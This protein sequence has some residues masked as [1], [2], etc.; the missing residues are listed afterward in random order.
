[1]RQAGVLAAA[2]IV[3]LE[4]MVS[5]LGQDHA[6]ARTLAEGLSENPC[7]VLDAGTPATNMVFMNLNDDVPQSA[8]EVAEKMKARGVLVGVSGARRFRLVTHC[9]IDDKGVETAVAAFGDVL[10]L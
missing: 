2:G 9:W 1:M 4:Q 7:L 10:N 8:A 3:A 6:R 5:R